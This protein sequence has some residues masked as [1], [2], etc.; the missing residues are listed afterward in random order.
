MKLFWTRLAISDLNSTYDFIAQ[1]NLSAAIRVI[2]RIQK[3]AAVLSQNPDIGRPGRVDGTRELIISGTPF[4][5]PYQIKG[6]RVEVL[7]V[8]HGARRWP[9]AF[10]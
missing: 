2:D 8:I 6:K 3:A 4:I 9:D 10:S 5:M 1:E 7:A